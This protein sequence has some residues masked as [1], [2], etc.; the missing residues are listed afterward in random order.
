[1]A[2]KRPR[3]RPP[4]ADVLTPGEWRVV[5]AVRHGLSNP[6][7][8]KR[9]GVSLD[10][11]KY[12]VANA[13]LKL[14]LSSRA[15]LR[16]WDGV[17]DGS[18]IKRRKEAAM[19]ADANS[20]GLAQICRTTADLEAANGFYGD[21]LGLPLLY[22]FPGM[23]FFQLGEARLYLQQTDKPAA[24]SI[25]YLRVGDIHAEHRRLEAKG[26]EFFNAPHMLYRHPNGTEEWMAE[27]RDNEGRPLAL[28]CQ[29]K[30][31]TEA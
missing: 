22:A 8:A 30:A 19:S 23:A 4:H 2:L 25:L 13:L 29:A 3:G 1:M 7:I 18:V 26:V 6:Q 11:V 27:F 24:E 15:E 12:H 21:I 31:L 14:G 20:I 10:A 28:M 16:R 17:H 5:E 9:Q